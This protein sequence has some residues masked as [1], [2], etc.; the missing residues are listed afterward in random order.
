MSVEIG[1]DYS[2]MHG[3]GRKKECEKGMHGRVNEE[4]GPY[5][6]VHRNQC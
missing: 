6:R 3:K 1:I 2:I 4:I 5:G